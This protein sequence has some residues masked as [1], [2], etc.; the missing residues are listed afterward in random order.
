ME[1][2]S[3]MT[4]PEGLMR[5]ASRLNSIQLPLYG[6]LVAVTRGEDMAR[7]DSELFL[8]GSGESSPFHCATMGSGPLGRIL[9]YL[10]GC[11]KEGFTFFPNDGPDC[12]YCPYYRICRFTSHNESRLK[13]N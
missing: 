8:L 2:I 7:V 13:R 1:E 11:L 9:E 3:P 10:L 5:L 4:K 6:F 12:P